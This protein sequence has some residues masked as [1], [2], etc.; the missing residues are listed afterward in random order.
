[1]NTNELNYSN[2]NKLYKSIWYN[3]NLIKELTARE[4]LIRYKSSFLGLT[5]TFITPLMLLIVYTF[6]FSF[7]FKAKWGIETN[8]TKTDFAI[9]LFVGLMI[10]SFFSEIINR[11]PG[12]ILS[13]VNYVKKVI[14]PLEILNIV[15]LSSA[16]LHLVISLV[17]LLFGFFILNGFLHWTIIFVPITLF[18]LLPITLGIGWVLASLGTYLRDINHLVGI[19]TTALLFLSPIFYPITILPK[20]YQKFFYINP[21]TLPIEQTRAVVIFGQFPD[22][23]SLSLYTIISL[24]LCWAGF[25]WFQKTRNGFADVL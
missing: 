11:S 10:H 23:T 14:F 13:N 5:W 2:L 22:W 24:L 20:I 9:I 17:I 4:V 25:W 12:L 7:V 1:M 16:F 18:P 6:I 21:L 15:T 19:F 8:E 3:R